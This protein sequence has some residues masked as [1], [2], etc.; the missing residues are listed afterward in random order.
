MVGA[1]LLPQVNLLP[2]E[3][4]ASRSLRA[5]K[6]VLGLVLIAVVAA[7]FL[8]YGAAS[9]RR[10]V[11]ESDLADAQAETQRLLT[12]QRD[13]AEVPLVLSSLEQSEQARILGMS[14]EILWAPYLREIVTTAPA[15]VQFASIEALG[16]TPL[17]PAAVLVSPLQSPRELTLTFSGRSLT[18]PDTAAWIESLE[19][20]AGFQ[21]A[22]I[23]TMTTTEGTTGPWSGQTFFQVT[24]SV[25]V[26]AEA[27]SRRF[28]DQEG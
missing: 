3:I 16:A 24:G 22:Y 4:R 6:R 8:G 21:D 2:P 27:Y 26:S 1:T 10:S 13:Y 14:T 12:A 5:L 7:S 20:I 25:Q 17:T 11:V 15:G 9:W 19:S 18:L 23:D 28:T